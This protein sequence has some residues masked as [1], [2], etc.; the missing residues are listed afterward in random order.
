MKH[1]YYYSLLLFGGILNAQ[2]GINTTNPRTTLEIAGDMEISSSIEIGNIDSM[3][4]TETSTFLVQDLDNTI[5]TLDVSNPIGAALGYIQEYIIYN[6]FQDFVRDFD[7]GIDATNYVVVAIS[8]F[9]D[10]ELSLFNASNQS[11]NFSLPYTSTI[12]DGGTW[13][14]VANYPVARNSDVNAQGTWTIKTLIFS[15]DLSKQFGTIVVPMSG[16]NT[17]A[18]IVPIID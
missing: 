6:P 17:G 3:V 12:I 7:T 9:Y 14:I 13:H 16:T 4:D 15:K 5:K 11:D 2:V 1:Y 18:A 8:A 10:E